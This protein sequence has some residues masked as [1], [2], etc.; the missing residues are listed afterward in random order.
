MP[1]TS[2]SAAAAAIGCVTCQTPPSFFS[3]VA[4]PAADVTL[5][6]SILSASSDAK[7]F[8][9]FFASVAPPSGSFQVTK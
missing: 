1:D 4:S 5:I 7:T 8:S 2:D 9:C 6:S 3:V